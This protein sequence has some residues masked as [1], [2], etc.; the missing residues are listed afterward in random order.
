MLPGLDGI[1]VCKRIQRDRPVPVLMLTARDSES[2][3]SSGSQSA[4][5]TT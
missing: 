2:D 3:L 1:E 4:P 5:T